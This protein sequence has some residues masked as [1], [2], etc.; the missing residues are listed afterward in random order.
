MS[1]AQ[2]A[3]KIKLSTGFDMTLEKNKT[4]V[5]RRQ[6]FIP[7]LATQAKDRKAEICLAKS[8]FPSLTLGLYYY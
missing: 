1:R 2:L 7:A 6:I 3:L 8:F 5:E 4:E